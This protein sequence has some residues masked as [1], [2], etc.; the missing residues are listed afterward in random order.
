MAGDTENQYISVITGDIIGSSSLKTTERE[1]LP[2]RLKKLFRDLGTA[3]DSFDLY[4]GDSFQGVVR[5][6]GQALKT[7]IRIRT[8]LMRTSR[9]QRASYDCRMAIGIG[10][11]SFIARN[12]LESDGEAFRYSGPALDTMGHDERIRIVSPWM[13]VNRE[14]HVACKL[15]DS[16]LR[17]WTA[18][19]AR[20]IS[21]TL[22]GRNQADIAALLR[23]TQPAVSKSLKTAGW[24]AIEEL[25][26]RYEALVKSHL[27]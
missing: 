22:R 7:A 10:K 16:I 1:Q 25:M 12:V 4:R 19:Q 6:P 18:V 24:N 5:E 13:E 26:K 15:A 20:I 2:A 9:E 11:A 21:E 8:G 17:R 14:M 3:P 27:Q 23:I